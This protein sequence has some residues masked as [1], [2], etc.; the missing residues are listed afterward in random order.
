[1]KL[2]S[3]ARIREWDAYTIAHEPV[4]SA[5]LM[6]RAAARCA[7]Q[8]LNRFAD[9]KNL[10]LF[11]GPGNN[12]G[13]GLALA[14]LLRPYFENVQVYAFGNPE[15]QSADFRTNRERLAHTD[16]P[17]RW[18]EEEAAWADLTEALA[19]PHTVAGDALFGTGL[20][21]PVTEGVFAKAIE[22]LNAGEAPVFSVDIPSGLFAD[23]DGHAVPQAR[24]V[25]ADVTYTFERPKLQFLFAENAGYTGRVEVVPIGLHT[26]FEESAD[27]TEFLL[28]RRGIAEL[29]RE[30]GPFSH[31][32]T[33]GHGLLVGGSKGK[34]GSVLLAVK[35]C[36]TAGAGLTTAWVPGSVLPVIQQQ[37]PEAMCLP[38]AD[39]AI[40]TETV[41][42]PANT[43]AMGIGPGL[44]TDPATARLLKN[45]L[46]ESGVPLV[47]DADALNILSE[48]KT[49]LSF[50]P[51]NTLLTP[52]PK[53]FDRLTHP[54][55]SG[56]ARW[57]TQVE[58]SKKYGVYVVLKGANTSISTPLGKTFF[59]TTGNAGMATGGSG[60]VLTGILTGLSAQ[61]YPAVDAALIGVFVHGLAGDFAFARKGREALVASDII[62]RLGDAFRHV[63]GE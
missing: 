38:M 26:G 62:H 39:E 56:Y 1:M 55:E 30:A 46:A 43:T 60:D 41:K 8:V 59:N 54:H 14:R 32:G 53:E 34:A 7:V 18:V 4:S 21:K 37:A 12:G 5:D 49:W 13:D 17:H 42:R 27:S 33:Y 44:G 58:F 3:A 22:A 20:S 45:L 6:E 25:R 47:L 24:V 28:S 61:G 19:R 35:A 51:P 9:K 23:T 40:L 29:K 31:K 57:K 50:L 52:H 11:C 63:F 10:I 48:N 15:K 36:M 16:I 2:F